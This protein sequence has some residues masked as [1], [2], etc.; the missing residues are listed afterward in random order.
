MDKYRA[1]F[2]KSGR[3]VYISHLDLLHTL[4][5]AF[6]RA[7]LKVKHSEGF[8]PHPYTSI[9]LPLPL[10]MSSD[11]ELLDFRLAEEVQPGSIA[12]RLNPVL[13]EGI[14]I[15]DVYE[16][17][18]K[19][20][21]IKWIR[22]TGRLEYDRGADDGVLDALRSFYAQESIVISKKTKRGTAQ[23]DIIPAF[24]ELSLAQEEGSVQLQAVVSA[25]EP[26][27]NPELFVE[28][29]RQKNAALVPDFAA[30]SRVENYDAE[31]KIFR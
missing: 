12:A 10:G 20:S 22:V 15:T 2:S 9:A 17:E 25:Q 31:M 27:F 6:C 16:P 14:E 30:F 4:Q 21:E 11:C 5:K 8:N 1:R 29:L 3:A 26:T 18:R 7:D 23:F 28:A 24:K 13:P 19:P